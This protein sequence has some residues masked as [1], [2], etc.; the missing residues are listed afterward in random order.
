MISDFQWQNYTSNILKNKNFKYG[1]ST[2]HLL[3]KEIRRN[4]SIRQYNIIIF[5]KIFF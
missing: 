3:I 2:E 4:K 1:S 5:D